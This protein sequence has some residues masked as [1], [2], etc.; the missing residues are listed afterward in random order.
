MGFGVWG[1]GLGFGVWGLGFRAT[2]N[3][4]SSPSKICMSTSLS[5]SVTLRARRPPEDRLHGFIQ[6]CLCQTA[7]YG[8]ILAD[9]GERAESQNILTC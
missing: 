2:R 6:M 4:I 5:D 9:I 3:N 7:V 1:L 8:A